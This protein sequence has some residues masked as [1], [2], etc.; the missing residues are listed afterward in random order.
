MRPRLA[1]ALLALV[2]CDSAAS[3]PSEAAGDHDSSSD[4]MT[5]LDWRGDGAADAGLSLDANSEPFDA[6]ADLPVARDGAAA[7]RP[8]SDI[9]PKL[10]GQ[11]VLETHAL[12]SRSG[13]ALRGWNAQ[14]SVRQNPPL[15]CRERPLAGCV[16]TR[17]DGPADSAALADIGVLTFEK[18]PPGDPFPLV[19]APTGGTYP[20]RQGAA[21]IFSG[22]Q[23]VTLSAAGS[24]HLPAFSLTSTAPALVDVVDPPVDGRTVL[25]VSRA[26]GLHLAWSVSAESA[27][28]GSV[29]VVLF[30]FVE[31]ISVRCSVPVSAGAYDLAAEAVAAIPVGEGGLTVTTAT[32][33]AITPGLEFVLTTIASAATEGPADGPIFVED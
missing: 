3:A 28:A 25:R 17:C 19:L 4:A 30:H 7:E 33:A 18:A 9:A 12:R 10:Y 8:D 14:A 11:V 26:K 23:A 1:L 13:A 2:G 5:D 6:S 27:P 31:P 20:D 32:R 15:H 29:E 21:M 24:T 22:G 16:V